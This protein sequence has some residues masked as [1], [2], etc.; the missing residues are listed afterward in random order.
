MIAISVIEIIVALLVL[1]LLAYIGFTYQPGTVVKIYKK[2]NRQ[3]QEEK[4]LFDYSKTEKFLK[5][6]G[7][8]Y[9][10]GNNMEPVRYYAIR[11]IC[12]LLGI[13]LGIRIHV[14]IALVLAIICYQLPQLYVQYANRQDNEKMLPDIKLI[15]NALFVQI[16]AGVFI[17]DA[18]SECYESVSYKRLKDALQEL[19]G[20]IVMKNDFEEAMNDFQ[21]RFD[22]KYIDSMNIILVQAMESGHSIELLSDISDQI[23]DMTSAVQLKKKAALDR[24]TTFYLLGIMVSLLAII[25]YAC[26]SQMFALVTNF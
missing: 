2:I 17:T 21:S 13:L 20:K 26:I 5:A 12:M 8:K 24:H 14:V 22:N 16:Q 6:N 10:I 7:A 11:L 25:L 1:I 18:V 15:Y 3:L 4:K 19:T 23:N 9:H